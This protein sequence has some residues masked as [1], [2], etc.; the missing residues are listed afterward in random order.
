M[1]CPVVD[2]ALYCGECSGHARG[3]ASGYNEQAISDG[4]CCEQ[5][6]AESEVPRDH[7]CPLEGDKVNC[8]CKGA[9]FS[10]SGNH[11]EAQADDT[12]SPLLSAEPTTF[13]VVANGARNE[14][15]KLATSAFAMLSGWEIRALIA[16]LT[17]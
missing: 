11:V 17:L 3:P 16:S 8:I 10:A 12:V 9:V 13:S 6:P 7:S 4:C 15:L 1:L 5:C 2:S 14:N